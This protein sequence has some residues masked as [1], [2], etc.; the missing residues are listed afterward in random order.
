MSFRRAAGA[1][2]LA[3]FLIFSLI[4]AFERFS[5]RVHG[6]TPPV[7]AEAWRPGLREVRSI[8][9]AMTVLPA[10]I[11][12]QSGSRQMRI[13]RGIDQFVRERFFHDTSLL[14]WRENALA[15]LTGYLWVNLREPVLPDDILHHRR[16]ICS[17]Q[18]IVAMELLKRYGLHRAAV[19]MAW[20]APDS[21]VQGHFAV[22]AQIDGQWMY[23]DPDQEPPIETVPVESVLDGTALTQLY[24]G[25]PALLAGMRYAATHG[26]A[27]MA[28]V[29]AFPAPHAGLFQRITAW[30]SAYGWLPMG[31]LGFLLLVPETSFPR[32]FSRLAAVP[33]R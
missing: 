33:A 26:T 11:A 28:W 5:P 22:A 24:G 17:Q 15:A 9:D 2:L 32:R 8:D 23:F 3:C 18:A 21:S 31:I 13:A 16:A 4:A 25:K 14:T 27:R 10:Y 19:M 12:R 1:F 20:P 30:L 7:L 29:D 6:S